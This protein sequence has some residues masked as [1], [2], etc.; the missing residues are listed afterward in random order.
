M[1]GITLRR[2]LSF[3]IRCCRRKNANARH[4]IF[5]R[6][7]NGA[8]ELL[9]AADVNHDGERNIKRTKKYFEKWRLAYL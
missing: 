5:W 4:L 3:V 2:I 6:T 8:G 7:D 9:S 1:G